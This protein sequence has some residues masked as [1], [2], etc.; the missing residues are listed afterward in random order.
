MSTVLTPPPAPPA[1][2]PAPSSDAPSHKPGGAAKV[3]AILT[4]V[5]G[6]I[7]VLGTIASTIFATVGA[8]STQTSG[9]TIAVSGVDE[10]DVELAAGSLRVEFADIDEAELTVTSAFGADR[11]TF[12][13]DGDRLVVASPRW[14]WGMGWMQQGDAVLRLPEGL[15]GTDAV[16]DVAAGDAVVDGG[17]GDLQVQLGAGRMQVSGTADTFG[18]EVSAGRGEFD[19]A[20]VN[21]ATLSVSA[22]SLDG[23]LTGDQP[24]TVDVDV[25]AGGLR[26]TV[27]DGEYD[28]TSDVSAGSFDDRVGSTS[29]AAST[30]AVQV[31]AGQAVLRAD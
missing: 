18:A 21:E 14:M 30:I 11:W 23:V 5:L 3:I 17:F 16:I 12:D 25:S 19:L 15:D 2:E 26:L 6:G 24:R 28:I 13:R 7:I 8:A 1:P 20:D 22:G 27:P 10:V 31:S 9:R 29:G 4:I